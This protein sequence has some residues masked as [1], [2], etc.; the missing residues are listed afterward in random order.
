MDLNQSIDSVVSSPSNISVEDPSLKKELS[1]LKD[2]WLTRF[3][4]IDTLLTMGSNL[5]SVTQPATIS[6]F[7]LVKVKVTHSPPA[8]FLSAS[9]FLSHTISSPS[10]SW[11]GSGSRTGTSSGC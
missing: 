6:V 5:L 3:G 2:E 7:S 9:H 1:D 8:G 10:A 11:F 4:C